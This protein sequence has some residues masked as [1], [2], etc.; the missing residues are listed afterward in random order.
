MISAYLDRFEEGWAVLLLG[1]EMKKMNV[2]R[3]YL[4]QGVQEGDYLT[5]DIRYD[6]DKTEAAEAEALSLL[7]EEG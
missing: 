1:D 3:A 2:P 4:P 6:K 5:I 7:H